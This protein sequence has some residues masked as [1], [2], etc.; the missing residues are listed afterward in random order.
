MILAIR[1]F[2][3]YD[4]RLL[5]NPEHADQKKQKNHREEQLALPKVSVHTEYIY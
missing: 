1:T 2:T 3:I 5:R 4:T